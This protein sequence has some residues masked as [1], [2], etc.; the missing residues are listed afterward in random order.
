MAFDSFIVT[1]GNESSQSDNESLGSSSSGSSGG[2][3]SGNSGSSWGG[4][5]NGKVTEEIVC[6]PPYIRYGKECCLDA[7]KNNIC[8]KDEISTISQENGTSNINNEIPKKEPLFLEVI[9]NT[10]GSMNNFLSS[11]EKSMIQN[12]NYLFLIFGIFIVLFLIIILIKTKKKGKSRKVKRIKATVLEPKYS[13]KV[14]LIGG[15]EYLEIK[16]V[17]SLKNEKRVNK[18]EGLL[19][20]KEFLSH[21]FNKYKKYPLNSIKGLINKKV[22]SENGDFIGN[23]SDISL[24][25]NRIS[26]LKIKLNKRYKFN[27]E[28]IIIDY[29]HV[30][31]V[32]EIIII[33]ETISKYLNKS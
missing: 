3:S 12:K 20:L 24:K 27:K 25:G 4:S 30:K 33:N 15:K 7:N 1:N 8:D 18:K 16:P 14:K 26:N 5:I 23:V 31:S 6:N 32:G 11:I 13:E 22:Y 17:K 2:S 21:L 10:I 29:Q 19:K 9:K 28:G